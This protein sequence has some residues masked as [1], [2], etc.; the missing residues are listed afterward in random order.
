MGKRGRRGRF[1]GFAPA[2]KKD[3]GGEKR[4]EGS[5]IPT[6]G[7]TKRGQEKK[8]IVTRGGGPERRQ[9]PPT[10][11]KTIQVAIN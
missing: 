4:G 5:K 9:S 11:R 6:C 3:S 1:S 10:F 7:V 2:K 8:S